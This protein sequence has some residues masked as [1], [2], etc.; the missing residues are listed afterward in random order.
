MCRALRTLFYFIVS[1]SE[2]L[3]FI[4]YT[5]TCMSIVFFEFMQG[6]ISWN[7]DWIQIWL[8]H[9]IRIFYWH[10]HITDPIICDGSHRS[11]SD[12]LTQRAVMHICGLFDNSGL[13]DCCLWL[14]IVLITL[15]SEAAQIWQH[16]KL[17]TFTSANHE[18]VVNT[19]LVGSWIPC[20]ARYWI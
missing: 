7:I 1:W 11:L 20:V 14:R 3:I 8:G 15:L 2:R 12:S 13:V 17:N 9:E 16:I 19:M 4:I 18:S 5:S 6:R 10:H